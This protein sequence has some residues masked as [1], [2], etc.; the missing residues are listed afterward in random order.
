MMPTSCN[1][2]VPSI[3]ATSGNVLPTSIP[4]A[5]ATASGGSGEDNFDGF[6]NSQSFGPP[7]LCPTCT[8]TNKTPTKTQATA[9]RKA[10]K[11]AK[12]KEIVENKSAAAAC[13]ADAKTKKQEKL[14]SAAKTK[15]QKAVTKAEKLRKKL[16]ETTKGAGA[17]TPVLSSGGTPHSN[18][19]S[20]GA[21]GRSTPTSSITAASSHMESP[22]HK[23]FSAKKR[24]NNSSPFQYPSPAPLSSSKSSRL[25][26]WDDTSGS[27]ESD[28]VA[29]VA[30][31]PHAFGVP[32][33]KQGGHRGAALPKRR[34]AVFTRE[35]TNAKFDS[36]LGMGS[37]S[38]G[39]K[40]KES[41]SSVDIGR[42]RGTSAARSSRSSGNT[43]IYQ[44]V[45]DQFNQEEDVIIEGIFPGN[46]DLSLISQFV[47]HHFAGVWEEY[48]P[49]N[50]WA[51]D[52]ALQ[53]PDAPIL[54]AKWKALKT[55]EREGQESGDC[56]TEEDHQH[57]RG[58][59]DD[60][61]GGNSNKTRGNYNKSQQTLGKDS[62]LQAP[63]CLFVSEHREEPGGTPVLLRQCDIRKM[64]LAPN[65]PSK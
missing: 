21:A 4:S 15:A 10:E 44:A 37:E 28:E 50:Q 55:E 48:V 62:L 54:I 13:R 53:D 41:N 61:Y 27:S 65:P 35:D 17:K 29:F 2:L 12:A 43:A 24:M 40:T 46:L 45:S 42:P 22:Q 5:G 59:G 26:A 63:K 33:Q 3:L 8:G 39:D 20:K 36:D 56:R 58:D 47:A 49:F 57:R 30:K 34:K 32:A 52:K 9:E 64:F 14:I 60:H 38:D 51:D 31:A 19:K 16:E 1:L 18:K 23:P 7:G 11:K 25:V 6:I